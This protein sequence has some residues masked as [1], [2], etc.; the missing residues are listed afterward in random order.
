MAKEIEVIFIEEKKGSFNLGQKKRVKLGYA[1]N[2]L[3]PKNYAVVANKENETKI[4][5]IQKK[6]NKR[7]EEI[8]KAALS[9]QNEIDKKTI[10]FKVKSHD[11]GKLYGSISLND[12]VNETNKT[13][14][15]TIDKHDL[16]SVQPL[17]EIGEY[18]IP[19]SIHPEV[20]ITI[21]INV[22]A[23]EEQKDKKS[24]PKKSKKETKEDVTE[25]G[26]AET[27]EEVETP[28]T[29]ESTES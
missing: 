17:K 9:I 24:T 27:Q 2:Y 6:A 26:D 11:E 18:T 4:L 23:E 14:K 29:K 10:T 8:K 20:K 5:S 7:K 16:K 28:S 15:T 3:L 21:T 13:Y 22:E 25:K 19:V 1:R 12:I